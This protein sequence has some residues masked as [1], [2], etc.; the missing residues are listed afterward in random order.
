M[1]GGH[2]GGAIPKVGPTGVRKIEL[3]R[4]SHRGISAA[5]GPGAWKDAVTRPTTRA[6]PTPLNSCNDIHDRTECGQLSSPFSRRGRGRRSVAAGCGARRV[7]DWRQRPP[8]GDLTTQPPA[9]SPQHRP[10][11]ALSMCTIA[12]FPEVLFTLLPSPQ[13]HA[14]G[15]RN[16]DSTSAETPRF[17]PFAHARDCSNFRQV[18]VSHKRNDGVYT[19]PNPV[20]P[21][22]GRRR[23]WSALAGPCVRGARLPLAAPAPFWKVCARRG[24]ISTKVPAY[25]YSLMNGALTCMLGGSQRSSFWFGPNFHLPVGESRRLPPHPSH[26]VR[27]QIF[28]GQSTRQ[29]KF[30]G[31]PGR[32]AVALCDSDN[33]E[34]AP[35]GKGNG[36]QYRRRKAYPARYLEAA[37][38]SAAPT[39]PLNWRRRAR[40]ISARCVQRCCAM[41][42]SSAG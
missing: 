11:S 35:Q 41:A 6:F 37:R 25:M 26:W 13:A 21:A 28:S 15:R 36:G 40:R 22:L 10:V 18:A 19:N 23:F 16:G 24:E 8:S 1:C 42:H 5:A 30:P 27:A 31:I 39:A 7:Q 3:V 17:H 29:K 9:A 38:R 20:P 12:I 32:S 34:L 14:L 4:A 33:L 2:A